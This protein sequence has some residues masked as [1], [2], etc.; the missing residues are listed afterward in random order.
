MGEIDL[1]CLACG[2][3]M[4]KCP[5]CKTYICIECGG[6]INKKAMK[7]RKKWAENI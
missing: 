6:Y 7:E 4:V 2:D 3:D 1:G 5:C